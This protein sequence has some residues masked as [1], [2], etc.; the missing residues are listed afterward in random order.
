MFRFAVL[1]SATIHACGK[2]R[3]KPLGTNFQ[4]NFTKIQE[5]GLTFFV[6]EVLLSPGK[7]L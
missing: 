1:D 5:K 2:W 6:N 4:D 7:N 3:R